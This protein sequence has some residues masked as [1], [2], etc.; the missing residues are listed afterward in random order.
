MIL[1]AI[2]KAVFSKTQTQLRKLLGMCNVYRRFVVD[3]AL[4]ANGV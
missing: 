2:K 1:K 4:K 3:P